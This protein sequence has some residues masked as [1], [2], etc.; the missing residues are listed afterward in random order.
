MRAR[1]PRRAQAQPDEIC[2][3]SPCTANT[4]AIERGQSCAQP[5]AQ[6]EENYRNNIKDYYDIVYTIV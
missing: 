1:Q 4:S 5:S 2:T 3:S 6:P